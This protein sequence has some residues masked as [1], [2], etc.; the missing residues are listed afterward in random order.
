MSKILFLGEHEQSEGELSMIL[1]ANFK[2]GADLYENGV[3]KRGR[4]GDDDIEIINGS[5]MAEADFQPHR[6]Q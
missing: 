2:E 3:T 1:K 4:M 5:G 6:P